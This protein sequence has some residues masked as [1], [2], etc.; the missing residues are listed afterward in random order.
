VHDHF[1]TGGMMKYIW[2]PR[3]GSEQLFNLDE[4]PKDFNDLAGHES[5][6]Q[7]PGDWRRRLI[8]CLQGGSEC[9]VNENEMVAGRRYSMRPDH[10]ESGNQTRN[11]TP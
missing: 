9:F 2:C 11:I 8:E 5:F 6:A 4:D 7:Q 1:L 10:L 3:N